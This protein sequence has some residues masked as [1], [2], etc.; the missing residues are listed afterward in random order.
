M[1]RGRNSSE[2]GAREGDVMPGV[3]SRS[4]FVG[5]A[6]AALLVLPVTAAGQYLKH[7]DPK[8][9]RTAD[10]KPNLTAPAPRAPDGKPDLNGLWNAVDG[11]FLTNIAQRAGFTAPFQPWAAALF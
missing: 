11:K 7:P 2:R 3:R 8:I 10:G 4:G 5:A 6:I 9:P 1:S